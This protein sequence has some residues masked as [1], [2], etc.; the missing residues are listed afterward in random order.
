MNI[1]KSLDQLSDENP[2]KSWAILM[3][4]F[5]GVHNGHRALIKEALIEC[6]IS[7]EELVIISFNPHPVCILNPDFKPFLINTYAQKKEL[8]SAVGVEHYVELSFT[9]DLSSMAPEDF[10]ETLILANKKVTSI[11]IGYDFAF[12]ANKKGN[13]KFILDYCGSRVRIKKFKVFQS[14]GEE[15]SSSV[16][17]HKLRASHIEHANKYL[18][19]EFYIEGLVTKGAGRGR[20]IGYPT[21]NLSFEKELLVPHKGVYVTTATL[22]G[23]TYQSITNIGINPT[24]NSDD[25]LGV[26]THIFD[27]DDDIYGETIKISFQSFLRDEKK[28][29]SVNDL[30]AQIKIDCFAAKIDR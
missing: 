10:L 15:L 20:Q 16:I 19:R 3:G 27:F 4:N 1:Y 18:G 2:G 14:G 12:G 26:E 25:I 5:D 24:F 11:F 21:A 17:R 7:N 30:V 6:K 22:R 23:M 28:F 8:L 13:Y 29:N 9:R